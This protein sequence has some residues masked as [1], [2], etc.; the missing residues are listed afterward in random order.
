M[1][2]DFNNDHSG[3]TQLFK[4]DKQERP[5]RTCDIGMVGGQNQISFMPD[6]KSNKCDGTV[7]CYT[8]CSKQISIWQIF[9]YLTFL[10]C[11]VPFI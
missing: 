8:S 11:C 9:F 7:W 5:L 6:M 4:Q 2:L 3:D 1:S 10:Y